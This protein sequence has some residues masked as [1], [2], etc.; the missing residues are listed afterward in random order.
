MVRVV[1]PGGLVTAYV[2]DLMNGGHPFEAMQVEMR[3][4]GI[5]PTLPPTASVSGIEAWNGNH[6][7]GIR[8][9]LNFPDV[10]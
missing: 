1:K 2:W 8:W 5:P 9:C 10:P 6:S 7:S 3:E 4:S